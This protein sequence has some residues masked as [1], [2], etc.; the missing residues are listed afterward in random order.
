MRDD[1]PY[2]IDGMV[3]KVN[4]LALQDKLG[5]DITSSTMGHCM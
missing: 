3:I 5:N 4:D 1:L 2:E